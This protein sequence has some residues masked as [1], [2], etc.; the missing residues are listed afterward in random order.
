MPRVVNLRTGAV[1]DIQLPMPAHFCQRIAVRDLPAFLR[2][3]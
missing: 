1:V 2:G 3:G